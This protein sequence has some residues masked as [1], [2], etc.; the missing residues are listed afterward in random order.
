MIAI[1]SCLDGSELKLYRLTITGNCCATKIH[2]IVETT[3][4]YVLR[5]KQIIWNENNVTKRMANCNEYL[6]IPF[7]QLNWGGEA[8]KQRRHV[9]LSPF[10]TFYATKILPCFVS[11]S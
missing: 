4:H 2:L 10:L 11:N 9:Y 1:I 7:Y 3:C 6:K 5:G 8:C